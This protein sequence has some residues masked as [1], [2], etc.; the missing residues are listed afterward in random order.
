M[1]SIVRGHGSIVGEGCDTG[2]II[3]KISEHPN[4]T[5]FCVIVK[6]RRQA[7]PSNK[8][9]FIEMK[10]QRYGEGWARLEEISEDKLPPSEIVKRIYP[11]F[12]VEDKKGSL[13][14]SSQWIL[15]K[16]ALNTK[17]DCRIAVQELLERRVIIETSP[18][19]Y[20]LN[21]DRF[22][23][24]STDYLRGLPYVNPWAVP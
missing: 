18:Q 2:Y 22:T 12:E 7:I 11:V 3:K 23:E 15:Q 16:C 17:R 24:C 21:P 1:T 13:N 8:I 9:H 6:P 5:R 4:P 10:E 19:N 14:H 20:S